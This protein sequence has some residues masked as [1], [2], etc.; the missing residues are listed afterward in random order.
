MEWGGMKHN[1]KEQKSFNKS[2]VVALPKWGKTQGE[3]KGYKVG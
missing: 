1:H 2:E 3:V